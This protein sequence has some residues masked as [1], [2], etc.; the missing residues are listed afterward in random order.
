[1]TSLPSAPVLAEALVTSVVDN[2]MHPTR[3]ATAVPIVKLLLSRA[4][5][6]RLL[7][8]LSTY[9]LLP[10]NY[11]AYGPLGRKYPNDILLLVES[12]LHGQPFGAWRRSTDQSV[13]RLHG[14]RERRR[15]TFAAAH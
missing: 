9:V 2:P 12:P 10:I 4:L 1:M 3:A 8:D 13:P 11:V 5:V 6:L 7:L 15:H 14:Q